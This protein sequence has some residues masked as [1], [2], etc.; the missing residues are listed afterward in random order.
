MSRDK[1]D[2]RQMRRAIGESALASFEKIGT[3]LDL[4]EMKLKSHAESLEGISN[5]LTRVETGARQQGE[6]IAG[7]QRQVN[8]VYTR[9][10]RFLEHQGYRAFEFA[11]D[12]LRPTTFFRR[13]RWLLTGRWV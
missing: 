13:L 8:D 4:D 2:R 9:L 6:V 7:Q 10:E 1:V 11:S 5:R 3:R 12:P